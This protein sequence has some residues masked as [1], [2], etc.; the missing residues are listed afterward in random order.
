VCN[1]TSWQHL[2]GLMSDPAG[3]AYL[4]WQ[5]SRAGQPDVY[6]Q[7]FDLAGSPQWAANGKAVCTAARGQYFAGI[8]YWKTAVPARVF[9]AWTDNRAITERYVFVQRLETA[10][11]DSQWLGDGLTGT[12]LA[13][14]SAS[15][16]TDRV[17]LV[18][19]ASE[20]VTATVYRRTAEQDW[21][22]IGEAYSDGSGMVAFEDRDVDPGARYQY[23]LGFLADG[24][25]TFA[26]EVWV[27]VPTNLLLAIDGLQPNP[28]VKD[29]LV[30]FTL[31]SDAAA[32]L[33]MID[34][35][36]R[37]LLARDLRGLPPGR[38]TLRLDEVR[39]PAGVYFIRLT[40]KDRTV[41]A[42]AAILN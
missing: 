10:N 42:R 31:P 6:A 12:T 2:T 23:R 24:Q 36:G 32:S 18:W 38:H 19:F 17:R 4:S 13:L 8:A 21:A 28:A 11:G 41:T 3:A 15:A 26:G 40:Q 34:V 35:A 5:D 16:E 22:P 29:L 1:A 27:E 7:R 20:N 9:V 33:E 30:S 14:V 37:R 39:P 25:E